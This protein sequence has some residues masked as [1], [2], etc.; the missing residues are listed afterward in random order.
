MGLQQRL[1]LILSESIL[2]LNFATAWRLAAD[3]YTFAQE[4]ADALVPSSMLRFIQGGTIAL[5]EAQ[6]T[7]E[8]W[9]VHRPED[10]PSE[11]TLLYPRD[12]VRMVAPLLNP[13]SLR[14]FYTFEKHAQMGFAK[15]GESIPSEWYEMPVYYKSATHNLLGTEA[16]VEWPPFTEKFDYELELVAVI[17]KRGRDIKAENAPNHIFG[18]SVM[19]DFSARDVQRKEMKVRLGPAK[20]KDWATAIGP[21]I[22][23]ADE[24]PNPQSL[25]MTARVNGELWSSGNSS[26][27]RWTFAQIIEFLSAGDEVRPGDLIASGTVGTGSGMEIDRWVSPGDL[28]ELEIERIGVLRNRVI[29]TGKPQ[30]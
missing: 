4:M 21:W 13:P 8:R 15:R 10:G 5:N 20:G 24:I 12:E 22:V 27:M 14:D 11:E 17:G 23:T 29:R 3:G 26:D 16:D 18:Y 30:T 9:C 7:F 1:G 2:D 28:M 6:V 25:A 19:N